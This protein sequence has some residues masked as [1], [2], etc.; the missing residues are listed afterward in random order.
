MEELSARGVQSGAGA[1]KLWGGVQRWG[2]EKEQEE[3]L[4]TQELARWKGHWG[5]PSRGPANAKAQRPKNPWG[6]GN[7]L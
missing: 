2:R 5:V 4:K 7:V 1:T 3:S 6:V